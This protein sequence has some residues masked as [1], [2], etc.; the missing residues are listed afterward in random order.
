MVADAIIAATRDSDARVRQAA[1]RTLVA[2]HSSAA[3]ARAREAATSDPSLINRGTALLTLTALDPTA[4]LAVAKTALGTDS[5]LDLSRT[6]AVMA[7]GK[8]DSPESLP[9]LMRY[10]GSSTSRNTRV[11]AIDALV[12]RAAGREAEV[13]A[14]IEPLLNVDD[15][16]FVRTEAAQ[17]L[18][19]LKQQSSIAALEARR[20]VEAESRVINTIDAALAAIRK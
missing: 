16:L 12:A 10:L 20:K 13:A 3:A 15:D 4:A 19:E 9:T 5:W 8:I 2:A 7:L 11:A 1:L 17:A 14:A 18:G 6:Q